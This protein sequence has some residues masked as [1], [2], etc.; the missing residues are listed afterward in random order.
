MSIL[1]PGLPG[2]R[3][4][5]NVHLRA[6]KSRC[7]RNSVAGE[8]SGSRSRS[9]FDPISFASAARVRRS[10]SVNTS[11]RR[12]SLARSS[13]FS[14]FRYSICAAAWRSS[15]Q[16]MLATRSARKVRGFH[17][18]HRCYEIPLP[19]ANSSFRTVR[20]PT[21]VFIS[22]LQPRTPFNDDIL[23]ER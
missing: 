21:G 13:R 11:R 5:R 2:L 3:R 4:S 12:P 8:T 1:V 16:P 15:Q 23:E 6:I 18:I 22:I 20:G 14:A 19:L 9:T 17:D 7:H 10:E